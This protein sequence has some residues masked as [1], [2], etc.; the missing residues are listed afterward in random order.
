M[1]SGMLKLNVLDESALF[2][3]TL[4]RLKEKMA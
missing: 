1:M 2:K 4:S 3:S